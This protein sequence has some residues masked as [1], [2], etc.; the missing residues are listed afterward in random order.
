[1][2]D[3]D[4]YFSSRFMHQG[5]SGAEFIYNE[6]L[7]RVKTAGFTI[8]SRSTL[9]PPASPSTFDGYLVPTG[10][11]GDWSGLDGQFVVWFNFWYPMAPQIGFQMYVQDENVWID[12]TTATPSQ[13]SAWDGQVN[14][15]LIFQTGS[16]RIIWNTGLGVTAFTLLTDN[17][18]FMAPTNMK[19]GRTYMLRVQQDGVGSRT[20]TVESNQ[21]ATAGQGP[22]NPLVIGTGVNAITDIYMMGPMVPLDVPTIFLQE[23]AVGLIA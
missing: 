14:V 19:P 21:F 16:E 15:P 8:I 10:A 2:A 18:I 22:S 4:P 3:N 5:T 23:L 1:M 7:A 13:S 17:A 9:A 12:F 20:L 6:F 11:T